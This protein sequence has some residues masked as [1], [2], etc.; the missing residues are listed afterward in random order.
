MTRA[1][2]VSNDPASTSILRRFE[3][4]GRDSANTCAAQ[5]ITGNPMRYSANGH[6]SDCASTLTRSGAT[7]RLRREPPVFWVGVDS[8]H[9]HTLAKCWVG[10]EHSSRRRCF[11]IIAVF[12][13]AHQKLPRGKGSLPPPS[14]AASW[15]RGLDHRHLLSNRS[16][17]SPTSFWQSSVR[18]KE[19]HDVAA[20]S[21]WELVPVCRQSTGLASRRAR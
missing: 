15:S 20:S 6:R 17:T 18:H 8:R 19:F 4:Y 10:T 11:P 1:P 21:E 12:S 2:P 14:C 9:Q 13:R 16:T 3:N 5:P 7:S